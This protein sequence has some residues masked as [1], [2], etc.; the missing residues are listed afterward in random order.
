MSAVAALRE[1]D[2]NFVWPVDLEPSRTQIR[3]H[4]EPHPPAGWPAC[5]L[6]SF[7]MQSALPGGTG[8][9]LRYVY[10]TYPVPGHLAT[11]DESFFR[12]EKLSTPDCKWVLWCKTGF[13]SAITCGKVA[14][15]REIF[16][17]QLQR[18]ERHKRRGLW[19][20][21]ISIPRT[22]SLSLSNSQNQQ[23]A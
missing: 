3:G 15:R 10:T 1:T 8:L 23:L 7:G 4:C 12:G 2:T 16:Y 11:R 19:A 6:Q 22:I 9:F 13:L 14:S 18:S 5:L 21:S 20:L 17:G